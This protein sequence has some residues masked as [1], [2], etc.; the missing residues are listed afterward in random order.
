MSKLTDELKERGKRFCLSPPR[1]GEAAGEP[2]TRWASSVMVTFP[3]WV[4]LSVSLGAATECPTSP[5]VVL[6]LVRDL[7]VR[8]PLPVKVAE[9]CGLGARAPVAPSEVPSC[10]SEMT[11]SSG[12]SSVA[13]RR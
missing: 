9:V 4:A 11:L 13:T 6:P 7:S 12:P 3:R 2:E 10:A 1:A 8:S 5:G